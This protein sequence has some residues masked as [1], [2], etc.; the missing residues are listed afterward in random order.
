M[1][2][3]INFTS[4]A[5]AECAGLNADGAEWYAVVVKESFTWDSDGRSVPLPEASPIAEED[6]C[7]AAPGASSVVLESD[8]VPVK[9][10]VDVVLVGHIESAEPVERVDAT[11]EVG[12]RIHKTVRVIGERIWVRGLWSPFLSYPPVRFTRM[13]IQLERSFGGQDAQAPTC[14]ERRNPWGR[15]MV[16][17]G[18]RLGGTLAPNFEDPKSLVRSSFSRP[19]PVGFGPVPRHAVPRI[20]LAGTYD[21]RWRE[22]RFPLL[23]EDFNPAFYNCAPEDQQL[24][25]YVAGEEIRLTGMTKQGRE[26]FLFPDWQVPVTVLEAGAQS[27]KL[28]IRADTILIEPA[29]QRFSLVGRVCVT[30]S[31]DLLAL[32]QIRVGVAPRAWERANT[33]GKRLVALG[34][35]DSEGDE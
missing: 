10:R 3:H 15:G 34:T 21:A 19:A 24:P 13:P 6:R 28:K 14:V 1:P 16:K 7:A 9:P 11:L 31:R 2:L 17:K 22:K 26:R 32:K 33:T 29:E 4:C 12:E 18:R 20:T 35:K 5:V 23:P 8:L 27:Q 25:S 30:P